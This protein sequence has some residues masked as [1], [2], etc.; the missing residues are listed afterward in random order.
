MELSRQRVH[1]VR[2]VTWGEDARRTRTGAAPVVLGCV[3]DIVRQALAAGWKN[4]KSGRRAHTNPDKA[5]ALHGIT[6]TQPVWI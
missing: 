3:T 2:D 6:R 5:L 1:Y 4:L